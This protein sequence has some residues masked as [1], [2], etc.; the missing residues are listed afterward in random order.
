MVQY[1]PAP[2]DLS[3]LNPIQRYLQKGEL[4]ARDFAYLF[5]FVLAYLAARPAIQRGIKWWMED[6]DLRAGE[7][8]QAEFLKAKLDPNVL[9]SSKAREA[10]S[11]PENHA[12]TTTGSSVDTKGNVMNRKTKDK[13]GTDALLDWDDLPARKP[14]EGDKTDVVSWMNKWSNEE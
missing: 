2:A 10:A 1:T 7:Q 3:Q 5:I 6:E 14:T 11:I 12:D 4:D 9:R 8:A 13:S